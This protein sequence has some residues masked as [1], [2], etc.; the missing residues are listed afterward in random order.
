MADFR[1]TFESLVADYNNWK[2]NF[3]THERYF[4]LNNVTY[5]EGGRVYV[6]GGF[7]NNPEM[8][9]KVQTET[10]CSTGILSERSE[11]ILPSGEVIPKAWVLDTPTYYADKEHNRIFNMDRCSGQIYYPHRDACPVFNKYHGFRFERPPSIKK[12]NEVL[13]ATEAMRVASLAAFRMDP[14]VRRARATF[15]SEAEFLGDWTPEQMVAVGGCSDA[16]WR[17][18]IKDAYSVIEKVPYL[19]VDRRYL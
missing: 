12:V 19:L 1:N 4:R 16:E 18:S 6:Q 8:R 7:C 3:D 14:T 15:Q 11:V 13:K 2:V 9:R 10:R 5:Y 17:K